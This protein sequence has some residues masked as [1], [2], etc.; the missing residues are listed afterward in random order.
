MLTSKQC[1]W[2]NNKCWLKLDK[3]QDKL[4]KTLTPLKAT[5]SLTDRAWTV[6]SQ[7]KEDHQW[8][9]P[10]KITLNLQEKVCQIRISIQII[11][12]LRTRNQ[13]WC[14]KPS[15]SKETTWQIRIQTGQTRDPTQIQFKGPQASTK[16]QWAWIWLVEISKLEIKRLKLLLNILSLRTSS[17]RFSNKCNL[18]KF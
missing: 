17:K 11:I 3:C 4:I 5:L 9:I 18:S 6:C 10:T 14:L 13:C 2:S 7:A 15:T 8:L 12:L 16:R 1:H